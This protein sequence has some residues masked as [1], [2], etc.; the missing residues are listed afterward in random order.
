MADITWSVSVDWDRNGS[1]DTDITDQIDN[2]GQGIL[3]DRGMDRNGIYQAARVSITVRDSTGLYAPQNSSSA[4]NGQ[5]RPLVPIKVQATHS[6]VTYTLFTGYIMSYRYSGI[7]AGGVPT[8]TFECTDLAG[9]LADYEPVDVTVATRTTDAAYTAI[10]TAVG[11]TGGDYNFPTGAQSLPVHWVHAQNA[12]EAMGEVLQSELGGSWYVDGLGV[13]QGE[14]RTARYGTT[15]DD[16]W[17]DG[18]SIYPRAVEVLIDKN[19]V[20]TSA[21]VQAQIL[22]E[23][24]DE[25][26]IFAFTRR[27]DNPTPDS[28][29]LA[30]GGRYEET[31]GFPNPVESIVTPVS[32]TDYTAN[33]AVD[34]T[35]T[36]R[37]SSLGVTASLLGG[38]FSLE[39]VNN[40]A[41][42]TIYVTHFQI[43]GLAHNIAPDR[44][45]Y[46]ATKSI[47]GDKVQRGVQV[48]LP[49]ADDSQP[50][51]DYA[52]HL[53][54]TWRY[55]PY[56]LKLSFTARN[57]SERAS[58]LGLEIGDLIKYKDTASTNTSY[59]N[60]WYYVE[61]IKHQVPPGM[62]GRTWVCEVEL[63]PSYMFR[64]L[65]KLVYDDFGRAN[66]SGDLGTAFSGDVW[67]DD[68][69]FDITS[70]KARANSNTAQYPNLDLGT[71]ATDQVFE[72]DL[73]SIAATDEVGLTLRFQSSSNT[74]RAYLKKDTNQ[75]VLDKVVAGVTT[76]LSTVSFTV[77]S[78]HDLRGMI[79]SNRIRV[80][81]DRVL[82]VDTTDSSLTTGT[83]VGFYA[84]N[85]SGSTTFAD[86]YGEGL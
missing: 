2:P 50:T 65:D 23:D 37:T 29:S 54:R 45:A 69:N 84:L 40:H 21:E 66:A 48:F 22:S 19:D 14:P 74:Y 44:P 81:V 82:K 8:C 67:A 71:G 55:E 9:V 25:V 51:R 17:G 35:G 85:A 78:S 36:D 80:W 76:A 56:R 33:T 58:M 46:R 6:A 15:V 34:G 13:I 42:D 1:Y 38:G 26:V 75:L 68:G 28:I 59:S 12:L 32:T 63:L 5:M 61:R 62:A 41:S 57:D 86:P 27:Y 60:D 20:I 30:P 31:F 53:L 64:R 39:L 24:V 16:T 11:L 3:I 47:S 79:Q 18:T 77:G 10:A 7:Q 83:K 52:I 72:V 43:R 73:A 70:N 49:F 4:R